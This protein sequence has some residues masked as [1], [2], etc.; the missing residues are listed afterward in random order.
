[1]SLLPCLVV[2]GHVGEVN[3]ACKGYFSHVSHR[4]RNGR[5]AG[6][7]VAVWRRAVPGWAASV[8]C[9]LR[10]GGVVA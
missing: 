6:V 7:W 3:A 5:S 10:P 1:M 8:S 4:A 9:E 2:Q